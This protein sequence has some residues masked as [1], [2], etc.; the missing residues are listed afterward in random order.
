MLATAS[1][2]SHYDARP[3][4]P[5][6][7]EV[8][9]APIPGAAISAGSRL[10]RK[11]SRDA[12]MDADDQ[13]AD[14]EDGSMTSSAVALGISGTTDTMNTGIRRCWW[15]ETCLEGVLI[16]A[17]PVIVIRMAHWMLPWVAGMKRQPSLEVASG[18]SIVAPNALI[19]ITT[20]TTIA[21][22]TATAPT[23]EML[24]RKPPPGAPSNE[25]PHCTQNK[26][27]LSAAENG[28]GMSL[29]MPL[30]EAP[31]LECYCTGH[32][33]EQTTAGDDYNNGAVDT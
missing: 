16:A 26:P 18:I 33:R 9:P 17:Q 12:H 2:S 4:A 7:T 20:P 3:R 19:A 10:D 8:S 25:R 11:P 28:P 13:H 6:M 27:K 30:P 5:A 32:V 22:P 31:S 23:V 1:F 21:T 15:P 14:W 24:P 29:S